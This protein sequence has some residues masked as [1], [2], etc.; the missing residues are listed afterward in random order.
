MTRLSRRGFIGTAAA[1]GCMLRCLSANLYGQIPNSEKLSD[2]A[3]RGR[4]FLES[5]FDPVLELLPEYRGADV[6]WLFHDNYLAARVLADKSP[7]LAAKITKSMQRFGSEHSGKIEIVF[8]EAQQPLPFRQYELRE[9]RRIDK[10]IV[11]T[12]VVKDTI[13]KGWEKYADLLFM[14]A[15]AE[16]D[17]R[18]ARENLDAGM[19]LWDGTGFKDQAAVSLKRYSTYKL[20][21]SLIAAGKLKVVLEQKT[22]ILEQLLALQAKDGGWVTDYDAARKPVGLTNVET[23]SLAIVAL[24]RLVGAE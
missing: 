24:E 2:A 17:P 8:G 6:Y 13:L 12:E 23:T 5:L 3:D 18:K 20:A 22:A 9:I 7:E 14:A 10:K 19:K 4:R 21:L 15:M 16:T 1:S 11:K